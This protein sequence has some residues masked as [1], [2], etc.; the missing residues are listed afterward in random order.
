[1]EELLAYAYLLGEDLISDVEYEEK[2][3]EMFLAN[4]TDED[5]LELEFLS[6][7]KKETIIY[8]RTRWSCVKI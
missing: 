2:L 8:I 4:P 7:S 5:L 6:G 1:M 3:N